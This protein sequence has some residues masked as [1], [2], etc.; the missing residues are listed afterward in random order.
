MCI[1]TALRRR[2][3]ENKTNYLSLMW[4]IWDKETTRTYTNILTQQE[5]CYFGEILLLF[6][7]IFNLLLFF[8][9]FR[10]IHLLFSSKYFN[11]ISG[12]LTHNMFLYRCEKRPPIKNE[13]KNW[14][15]EKMSRFVEVYIKENRT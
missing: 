15:L 13:K 5:M 6:F 3:K 1:A 14:I 7:P 8:L 10:S 4:K 9:F 12:Y 11:L 2:T